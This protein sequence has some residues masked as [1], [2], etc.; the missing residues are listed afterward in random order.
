MAPRWASYQRSF[1]QRDWTTT[2][3]AQ[4]TAWPDAPLNFRPHTSNSNGPSVFRRKTTTANAT[5]PKPVRPIVARKW[6][7]TMPCQVSKFERATNQITRVERT[8]TAATEPQSA[9]MRRF[10]LNL[11]S[12]S[13][14]PGSFPARLGAD[15][16]LPSLIVSSDRPERR[17]E[18]L[19]WQSRNDCNDCHVGQRKAPALRPGPSRL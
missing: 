15:N 18:C 7:C 9:I 10:L 16:A 2:Q 1:A 3:N 5:I 4:I 6:L 13:W 11:T 8:P 19:R 17:I 12:H 14:G